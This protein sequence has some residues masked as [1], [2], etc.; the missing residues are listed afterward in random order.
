M[1]VEQ[2]VSFGRCEVAAEVAALIAV[3]GGLDYLLRDCVRSHELELR[4]AGWR[5]DWHRWGVIVLDLV[6]LLQE[7][8]QRH[9]DGVA[10]WLMR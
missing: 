2:R 3:G 10:R 9:C 7:V 8:F 6:F 4:G 5:S 1:S